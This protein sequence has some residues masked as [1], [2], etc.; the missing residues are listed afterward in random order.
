MLIEYL[1]GEPHN[2]SYYFI[3][4]ANPYL[5][6]WLMLILFLM[7]VF[8]QLTYYLSHHVK[9][10]QPVY[11]GSSQEKI[12]LNQTQPIGGE[13]NSESDTPYELRI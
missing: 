10:G 13:T 5:A 4:S 6:L 1:M 8:F 3:S 2:P 7:V 9:P 11:L 12:N